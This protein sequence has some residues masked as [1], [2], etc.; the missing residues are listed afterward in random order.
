MIDADAEAP[1]PFVAKKKKAHIFPKA[2]VCTPYVR[3]G[4]SFHF[5][6]PNQPRYKKTPETSNFSSREEK[7]NKAG[8]AESLI[9]PVRPPSDICTASPMAPPSC[10]LQV[11]LID[12]NLLER[13][14]WMSVDRLGPG[15]SGTPD[16]GDSCSEEC[17]RWRIC[18][19]DLP[20]SM[21]RGR[22]NSS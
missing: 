7:K 16:F 21:T 6:N 11:R 15:G 13:S 2:C 17:L 9:S 18:P 12:P 14:S 20:S 8:N 19:E 22:S 3:T 4:S 10:P 5:I 1:L